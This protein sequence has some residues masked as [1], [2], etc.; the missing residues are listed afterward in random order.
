MQ[1]RRL[2]DCPKPAR[3]PF[4]HPDTRKA[5]GH[6]RPNHLMNQSCS[7]RPFKNRQNGSTEEI[8]SRSL[9]L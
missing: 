8:F 7:S 1:N 5:M 2:R 9:G 6:R 4:R 3:C